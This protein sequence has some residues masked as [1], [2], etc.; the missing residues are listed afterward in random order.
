M[1][2][3]DQH[4]RVM[5]KLRVSL[6]E[7]CNYSCFYCMPEQSHFQP[8]QNLLSPQQI[9]HIVSLLSL[10]GLEEVRVT[11]GEPTMRP[12]FREIM[13]LLG[14]IEGIRLNLTTNGQM[15]ERDLT[16]LQ[17]HNLK[18]INFS[19]DSLDPGRFHKITQGGDLNK[20]LKCIYQ[21]QELGIQVKINCIPMQGVNQDELG[22]FVQWGAQHQIEVR[23]L[24]LMRIGTMA[25]SNLKY[26][27][28]AAEIRQQLETYQL[29]GLPVPSDSTSQ[30]YSTS[31]GSSIGIIASETEPFCSGC[32]RLRLAATGLLKPCLFKE[33]GI[34]FKDLRPDQYQAKLE[35]LVLMKPI[36][37]IASIDQAMHQ[38]GG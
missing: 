10:F 35:E 32:S 23:F 20:V 21:A 4:Q 18:N 7:A 24:E 15:L 17:E 14:N 34:Q 1:V 29:Q 13:S 8:K 9:Q 30:R 16:L 31:L 36:H 28:S 12:E 6:T 2:I 37:R 5:K 38:I 27:I 25:H 26:F 11:G 33:E 3:Q 22:D 19:L